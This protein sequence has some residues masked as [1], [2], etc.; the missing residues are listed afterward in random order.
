M[1][2]RKLAAAAALAT[3]CVLAP[4]PAQAQNLQITDPAGDAPSGGLDITAATVSNRDRA[5][6]VRVSFERAMRGELIVG[7]KARDGGRVVAVSEH[8]P[9]RGDRNFLFKPATGE[10]WDCRGF[11]VTW[12]HDSDTA[13]V[14]L[15]SRCLD[16]G[17]YGAVRV[18]LLTEEAGGGAD[19]DTAPETA[20]GWTT[21]IPRG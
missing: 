19:M 20:T 1:N 8:R 3:V 5:V 18:F 12:D 6:V 15:P 2:R 21:W 9:L 4:A 14:R 17:D 13:T 11:G 10:K 7:V 16:G